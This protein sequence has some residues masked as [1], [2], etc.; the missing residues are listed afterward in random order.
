MS[1]SPRLLQPPTWPTRP[2][3]RWLRTAAASVA[4]LLAVSAITFALVQ[5]AP[6]DAAS[7]ILGEAAT[8]QSLTQLRTQMGLDQPLHMR[9]LRWLGDVLR[10]DLGTLHR[11]G[12]PVAGAIAGRLPVTLQLLVGAQL[13]AL[14]FAVPA[15]IRGAYRERGAFD[16]VVQ[17]LATGFVSTPS[18]LIGLLLVYVFA[19]TLGWL[20]A[21]GFVPLREDVVGN[22][23]TMLLPALT[24]G[25]AEF[26]AYMRLLRSEMLQTLQQNFI[27]TA[28]AM[29]LPPWR[30]L[31]QHALRPSSLSLVTAIG[32]N[33]GRLLGGA[34]IIEVLFGL[35]GIGSL[36]AES[37]YQRE[38]AA[39]QGIVLFVA[40]A[41][42]A[43]NLA[44]DAVYTWLDPRIRHHG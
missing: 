1:A 37:I 2:L 42:V 26:P 39:V 19:L 34:V 23:R 35:P 12:E 22:L 8:T 28:R 30:I 14:L 38:Y 24:L 18:F 41:F 9:Y 16:R 31:L 25:L 3:S 15:A 40:V 6:G 11:S 33:M 7:A 27:L 13:F 20:P 10:G 36:L 44:V 21:T 17:T 29:G 5:A 43:I 32:I 4:I